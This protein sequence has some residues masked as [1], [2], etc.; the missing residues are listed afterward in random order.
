V[1]PRQ[2]SEDG[3]TTSILASIKDIVK[4]PLRVDFAGGWLDVPKFARSDGYIVNCTILP[5]VSLTEWPYQKN[6][7]LGGSAAYAIL[8][9]RSGVR[10]ELDQGVGWQ[11]PAVIEET[12]ICVWR[13]GEKPVLD[14][15]LNPDWLTGRMLIFWTG[16][17]RAAS[18]QVMRPRDFDRLVR[19]GAIAREAVYHRDVAQ[20]AKAMALN[21]EVQKDEGME[22]LPEVDNALGKKYLG[23]GHGGYALYLFEDAERRNAA[24]AAHKEAF[25]IEPYIKHVQVI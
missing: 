6:A 16:K 12:G 5:P 11:D 17:Q 10:A 25:L 1:I 3:S 21:Y 13:S 7:G 14:I 23:A 8:Q 19:A 15:K 20:L 24:F 4:V 22:D 18:D 9:A 2:F